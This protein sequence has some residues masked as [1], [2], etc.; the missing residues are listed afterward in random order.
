M[1][2]ASLSSLQTATTDCAA[3]V[4]SFSPD[5]AAVCLLGTDEL[6]HGEAGALPAATHQAAAAGQ[7]TLT[8]LQLPAEVLILV[9]CRLDTLSVARFATTC[10]EL[11]RGR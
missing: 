9:L 3:Q 2:F 5:E 10:S 7:A 6:G 11:Y 8:L 4:A 1:S